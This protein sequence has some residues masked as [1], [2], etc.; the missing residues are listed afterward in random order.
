MLNVPGVVTSLSQICGAFNLVPKLL[1]I[2]LANSNGRLLLLPDAIS[3]NA[4]SGAL[5]H[6]GCWVRS[7]TASAVHPTIL[8]SKFRHSPVPRQRIQ[9]QTAALYLAVRSRKPCIEAA[10]SL[11]LAEAQQQADRLLGPE[12]PQTCGVAAT[13]RHK[14]GMRDRQETRF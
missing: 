6:Q 3:L 10:A 9:H 14:R 12:A 7:L 11:L 13:P 4:A 1:K 8:T 5:E 2:L